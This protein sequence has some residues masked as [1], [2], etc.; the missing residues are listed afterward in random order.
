MTG[1]DTGGKV[2]I[3]VHFYCK[4][5]SR[6]ATYW[7]QRFQAYSSFG[8]RHQIAAKDI[9]CSGIG[10]AGGA[11]SASLRQDGLSVVGQRRGG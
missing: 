1:R 5:T 7:E 9:R 2:A 10:V 3:A 8:L 6:V 4:K 11:R